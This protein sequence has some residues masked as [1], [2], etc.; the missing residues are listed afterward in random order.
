M[1]KRI[2]GGPFR[3]GVVGAGNVGSEVIPKLE[4]PD[5]GY[6]LGGVAVR[7]PDKY[8]HLGIDF[9]SLRDILRDPSID[10]FV[11]LTADPEAAGWMAEAMASG[12]GV[13]SANK[14]ALAGA[15]GP[16]LINEAMLRQADLGIEATVG[17]GVPIIGPLVN[18]LRVDNPLSTRQINNG[19]TNAILSGMAQGNS[20][21]IVLDDAIARGLAE[22]N[23]ASDTEGHDS[24]F[25]LSIMASLIFR[26]LVPPEVISRR[27]I[28]EI[29]PFDL[30]FA[31]QYLT[32]VEG[33]GYAIKLLSTARKRDDGLYEL[34]VSPA[35]ISLDQLLARV[36]GANNGFE[37]D[38]ENAGQHL[39]YGEGAGGRP[40][41]MAVLE[42]IDTV[43]QNRRHG[44]ITEYPELQSFNPQLFIAQGTADAR[45]PI[46][47]QRPDG[48]SISLP[49]EE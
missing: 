39:T 16:K 36:D 9:A 34:R 27:G 31:K 42:N 14:K 49:I 12:K 33:P 18:R 35:L 29:T 22:R 15:T 40:T 43:A 21:D 2:E 7:Q 48:T 20:F 38:W 13:V 23:H 44:V 8:G 37:I 10:I 41:S 5:R 46:D 30:E 26:Q 19:T 3:V 1:A 28:T 6:V 11:D 47:I 4:R 32:D 25:K 24:A 45:R 17:G